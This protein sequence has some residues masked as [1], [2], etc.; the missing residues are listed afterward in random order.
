MLLT[1]DGIEL[2]T[3][4]DIGSPPNLVD[5]IWIDKPEYSQDSAFIHP[6]E[7]AGDF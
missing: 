7:Y 5:E 2:V 4:E 3:D 1:A 6:I